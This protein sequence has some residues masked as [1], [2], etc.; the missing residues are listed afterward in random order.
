MYRDN[1]FVYEAIASLEDIIGIPIAIESVRETYDV[2][3][4]INNKTFYCIAKKNAKNANYGIII[5]A[6]ND[7]T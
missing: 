2:V 3:L 4:Q 5:S 7:I 1:D 6:M